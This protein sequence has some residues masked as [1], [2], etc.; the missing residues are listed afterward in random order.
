MNLRKM[1]G[2][3]MRILNRVIA[4]SLLVVPIGLGVSGIAVADVAADNSV[5]PTQ[6]GSTEDEDP[7]DCDDQDSGF[8]NIL[9]LGGDSED[10]E[11]GGDDGEHNNSNGPLG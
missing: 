11:C 7:D 3:S 6:V 5:P 10:G 8:L 2:K 9:N 1:E 4:T